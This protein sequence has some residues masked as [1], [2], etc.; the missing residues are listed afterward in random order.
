MKQAFI[1]HFNARFNNYLILH[2][3]SPFMAACPDININFKGSA[4]DLI[5]KIKH[6]A[7]KAGGTLNGDSSSGSVSFK[8]PGAGKMEITYSV[9]EEL[10]TISIIE[11]PFF[12]PCSAIQ[13]AAE[14]IFSGI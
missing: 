5:S 14:K 7:E 13:P 9:K 8:I 2:Y 10:I 6:E 11:K 12:I 1:N 4:T 3:I